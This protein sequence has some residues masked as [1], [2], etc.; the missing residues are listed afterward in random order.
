LCCTTLQVD[1][2]N[3]KKLVAI[4]HIQCNECNNVLLLLLLLL[5]NPAG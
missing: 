5:P 4:I 3:F 2:A 1:D